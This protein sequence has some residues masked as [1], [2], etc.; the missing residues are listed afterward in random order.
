M[1]NKKHM[2]ILFVLYLLI[3]LRVIVFKYP[4]WQIREIAASW[5]RDVFWEGLGSANFT[6]FK[7]IRMY[8]KY[9]DNKGINSFGN[10]IGN[11]VAFIPMGYMLPR[12]FKASKHLL[13]CMLQGF[14][15]I[16]GI[17]LFQLFSAFGIFDVDDILLNCLGVFLGFLFFKIMKLFSP[18]GSLNK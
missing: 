10:L 18:K 12:I 7:T 11:V 5:R 1:I 15:F 3:L 9:W 14:L 2:R 17:E 13:V 16:L 8:I 6:F 4:W